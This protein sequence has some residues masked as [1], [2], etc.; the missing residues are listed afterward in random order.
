MPACN[1][2]TRDRHPEVTYLYLRDVEALDRVFE[3]QPFMKYLIAHKL[4][5]LTLLPFMKPVASRECLICPA[6]PKQPGYD[7][8]AD[9]LVHQLDPPDAARLSP[10]ATDKRHELHLEKNEELQLEET[11][12]FPRKLACYVCGEPLDRYPEH[13][14]YLQPCYSIQLSEDSQEDTDLDDQVFLC[15]SC[16]SVQATKTM[17]PLSLRE[18]RVLREH[19]S[20]F[21]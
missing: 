6:A 10:E 13:M 21:E 11:K 16:D 12:E 5:H 18:Q 17:G 15:E 9:C 8:C 1:Q 4:S 14:A 2:I 3:A 20:N 7:L 19:Y